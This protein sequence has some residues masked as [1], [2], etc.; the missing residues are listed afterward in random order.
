MDILELENTIT[1]SLN[2]LSGGGDD[3]I[4]LVNLRS[5]NRIK[6]I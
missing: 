1:N 5:D 4:V 6:P 3:R 2:G